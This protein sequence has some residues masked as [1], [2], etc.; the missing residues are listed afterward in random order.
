[1]PV[2]RSALVLFALVAALAAPGLGRGADFTKT[3][4]K[5]TMSDGVEL[6]ATYF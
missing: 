5:M 1:M 6:A 3:D 4:L 2:R